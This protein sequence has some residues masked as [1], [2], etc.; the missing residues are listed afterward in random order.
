MAAVGLVD[1]QDQADFFQLFQRAINGDQANT[2][3][4]LARPQKDLGR[5]QGELAIGENFHHGLAR[6]GQPVSTGL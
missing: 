3:V 6:T 2:G 4:I 5:I 1:A